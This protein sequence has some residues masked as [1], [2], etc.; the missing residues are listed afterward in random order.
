MGFTP[1]SLPLGLQIAGQPYAE[2]TVYRVGYAY[3][4]AT[5]WH[6]RHPELERT[7]E[8]RLPQRVG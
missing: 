3:E 4:R 2:Q 1:D 5:L 8:R 7:L 6:A